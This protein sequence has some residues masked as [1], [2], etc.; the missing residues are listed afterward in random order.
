MSFVI[1]GSAGVEVEPEWTPQSTAKL[2]SIL[3][4]IRKLAS[5]TL[6]MK[7]DA[8]GLVHDVTAAVRSVEK[9]IPRLQLEI[10]LKTSDVA[11]VRAQLAALAKLAP[12]STMR[13]RTDT[14]DD[15]DLGERLRG[16]KDTVDLD[17]RLSKASL[18]KIK[19]Q[20]Q[21]LRGTIDATI[22]LNQASVAAVKERVDNIDATIEAELDDTQ[23]RAQKTRLERI[24]DGVD[25][26]VTV[27][28][29]SSVARA[30]LAY[31]TR[32]RTVQIVPMMNRGAY[33]AVERALDRLGQTSGLK[34][35][36]QTL[37]S[38]GQSF[39][40]ITAMK[41]GLLASSIHVLN[42]ALIVLG[43]NALS[44]ARDM[45]KLA[46]VGIALPG[47]FAAAAASLTT[48]VW[49][50]KDMNVQAPELI[51][52]WKQLKVS[53]SENFWATARQ[54]ILDMANRVMPRL[55]SAWSRAARSMGSEAGHFSDAMGRV[56]GGSFFDRFFADIEEGGR[57]FRPAL[58]PMLQ[59]LADLV[60]FGTSQLPRLSTWMSEMATNWGR[61][62]SR[63]A[64]DGT[65]QRWVDDGVQAMR[66]LKSVLGGFFGSLGAI[67]KAAEA[68]GGTTLASLA[69]GLQRLKELLHSDEMQE[70]MT[71]IFVTARETMSAFFD[72]AE[73]GFKTFMTSMTAVAH[74]VG[75]MLGEALGNLVSTIGQLLGSDAV[76]AGLTSL[77]ESLYAT[78][79]AVSPI[80]MEFAE[81]LGV[82]LESVGRL[83]EAAFPALVGILGSV[84]EAFAPLSERLADLAIAVMPLI[85]E[86]LSRL[87]LALGNALADPAVLE[88]L[89]N[90]FTG[91]TEAIV[92]LLPHL[93]TLV[94]LVV[95]L[96]NFLADVILP[97][98]PGII[99]A[100]NWLI[101][102]LLGVVTA[103]K[104]IVPAMMLVKVAAALGFAIGGPVAIAVAAIA[105]I[106]AALAWVILNWDTV[107][108]VAG[109]VIDW[110]G[111]AL[112]GLWDSVVKLFGGLPEFF[113]TVFS[114]LPGII[115]EFIKGIPGMIGDTLK[116]VGDFLGDLF[117]GKVFE[118][119]QVK[120]PGEASLNDYRL[121]GDGGGVGFTYAPTINN[122]QTQSLSQELSRDANRAATYMPWG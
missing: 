91:I 1:V 23:V 110:L 29:N 33:L 84:L 100:L 25:A 65:F 87:A 105:A 17:A 51:E 40:S 35:L 10:A 11:R 69:D 116:G 27:S 96:G 80:L 104:L 49:A 64:S 43:G 16:G 56:L 50:F 18:A 67:G 13:V 76:T 24:F 99:G 3:K 55:E 81:P 7:L 32:H 26:A 72:A 71:R 60:T 46:G 47:L 101:P 34:S 30:R 86:A 98:L 63:M 94:D 108:E 77:F 109:G 9:Q 41:F 12:T 20:L 92:A 93:P 14:D 2:M 57:R 42:S 89:I 106:V 102:L 61:D 66:D 19:A 95:H 68:A 6:K 73:P 78:V 121:G 85:E 54:P 70:S 90:L 113:G 15:F 111:K 118:G 37:A 112:G 45:R 107:K 39:S 38:L 79:D 97:A 22:D 59:G 115:W 119:P 103:V 44:L 52:T 28:L 5:V 58:D 53:V 74:N 88:M 83:A 117:T 120:A 8:R 21:N 114:Q 36:N 122:P 62:M 82:I 75:P 4:S 48:W 31:L